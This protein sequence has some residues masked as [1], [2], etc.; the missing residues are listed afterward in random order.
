MDDVRSCEEAMIGD[1]D[2]DNAP[3]LVQR[4]LRLLVSHLSFSYLLYRLSNPPA[5]QQESSPR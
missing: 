2:D 3:T 4:T 5:D 1:T